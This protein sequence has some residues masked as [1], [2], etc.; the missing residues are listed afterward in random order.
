VVSHRRR[1]QVLEVAASVFFEKG[2]SAAT[3]EDIAERV[4]I[5]KG[6][7]YYYFET[8]EELLFEI[9]DG[10]FNFGLE[11]ER[12]VRQTGGSPLEQLRA[13][14]RLHIMQLGEHLEPGA[15]L[16][17][18]TR[19]LSPERRAIIRR[20]ERE[21]SSFFTERISD[22]IKDGS[23]RRDVDPQLAAYAILGAVNSMYRWYRPD[24]KVSLR[25]TADQYSALLIDGLVVPRP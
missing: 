3:I 12:H 7:L 2:Y 9:V 24:R 17:N 25:R 11:N 21:Y 19:S 8:K 23:I 1:Q 10:V 5:L 22:G 18:D 15:V 4:G 20:K 14:I 13:L 16:L 6:S